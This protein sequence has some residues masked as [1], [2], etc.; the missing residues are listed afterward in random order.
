MMTQ[1]HLCFKHFVCLRLLAIFENAEKFTFR[2]FNPPNDKEI[3]I[4]ISKYLLT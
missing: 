3:S 1:Y 4:S 2:I